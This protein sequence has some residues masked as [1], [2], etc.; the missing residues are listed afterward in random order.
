MTIESQA[1]DHVNGAVIVN[2][3]PENRDE[4]MNADFLGDVESHNGEDEL[5]DLR[6][7]AEELGL[8]VT[9]SSSRRAYRS[10][11]CMFLF[12]L[13]KNLPELLNEEFV[14]A[15]SVRSGRGLN[16]L[17]SK[18]KIRKYLETPRNN[19]PPLNMELFEATHFSMWLLSLEK[20][21]MISMILRYSF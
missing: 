21:E 5:N 6:R 12:W 4:E 19:A 11:N 2:V 15:V 1:Q 8:K 20:V 7:Q 3:Q 13:S 10:S 18:Q 16:G 14:A 17:V 9:S